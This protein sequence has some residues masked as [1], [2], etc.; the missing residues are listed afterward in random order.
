MKGARVDL[1]TEQILDLR[2]LVT[3]V[4]S[5]NDSV[6]AQHGHDESAFPPARPSAVVMVSTTQ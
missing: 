1:S 5:T 6:L 4:V 3:G 2:A